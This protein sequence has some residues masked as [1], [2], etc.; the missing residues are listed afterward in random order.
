MSRDVNTFRVGLFILVSAGLV[1]G[2]AVMWGVI[3]YAH[4]TRTYVTYFD[5]SVQGLAKNSPVKWRGVTIGTVSS[6]GLSDVGT[7]IEVEMRIDRSFVVDTAMVARVLS[8]GITGMSYISIEPHIA[9]EHPPLVLGF[10]PEHT[11]IPSAPSPTMASL[12]DLMEQR[13]K[14]LD[15]KSISDNL[16]NI[17]QQISLL[18]ADEH[19]HAMRTNLM[20]AVEYVSHILD[21]VDTYMSSESAHQMLNNVEEFTD[22]MNHT[23]FIIEGRS[24]EMLQSVQIILNNMRAFSEEL[25]VRPAQTLL[26]EQK[27][28][29]Q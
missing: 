7:F 27:E 2:A 6:I 3:R 5:Q 12:M 19:Y 20:N 22:R 10:K 8:P 16:T 13:M 28:T 17:L 21:T 24:G 26:G 15:M 29:D 9:A 25:R 11:Y 18:M 4:E 14:E 1:I 23:L